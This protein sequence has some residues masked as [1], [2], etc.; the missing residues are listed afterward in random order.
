MESRN[1]RAE[2]CCCTG[3]DEG[4]RQ[5]CLGLVLTQL[6][7]AAHGPRKEDPIFREKGNGDFYFGYWLNPEESGRKLM[8]KFLRRPQGTRIKI[9]QSLQLE[10][11]PGAWRALIWLGRGF[12][13]PTGFATMLVMIA[14]QQKVAITS[15]SSASTPV[16][17]LVGVL[18]LHPQA[19]ASLSAHRVEH[20]EL[21]SSSPSLDKNLPGLCYMET[22]VPLWLHL[23]AW[24][25]R[26][27]SAWLWGGTPPQIRCGKGMNCANWSHF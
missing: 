9:N 26:G 6:P 23:T 18:P 25:S 2:S 12:P 1:K 4:L 7:T 3:W 10:K 11:G 8:R 16:S 14:A 17:K 22:F 15:F 19:W 21:P 13:S 5:L 20:H 24:D 27:C